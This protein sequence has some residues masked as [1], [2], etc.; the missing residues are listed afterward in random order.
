VPA[1]TTHW[2]DVPGA[3]LYCEVRGDGPLLMLVGNPMGASGFAPVAC[4][5][6]KDFTVVTYDPRGLFRSTIEDPGQDAEPGLLAD[7]VSQVLEAV[8]DG[9]AFVFGSSGG[10]VTGLAL[11]TRHPASLRALVA[12]EPPLALLLPDAEK[13]L[14]GIHAIYD[15]YCNQGTRA[16]WQLFSAF[17]DI[18]APTQDEPR[19]GRPSGTS[20]RFFGHGLLPTALYMPDLSALQAAPAEVIV[21]GGAASKGQFAWRAAAALAGRLGTPLVEFPGGHTGFASNP[22]DFASK[23]SHLLAHAGTGR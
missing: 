20:E 13:A 22:R 18:D 14:A 3:R 12:H 19:E 1:P 16:A 23:L 21:G 11:V 10:A 15:A 7:D 9:P 6:A 2:V 17:S 8:G 4:L 5:L